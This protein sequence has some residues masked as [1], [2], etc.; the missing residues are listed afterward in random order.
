MKTYKLKNFK[1]GWICGNFLPSIIQTKL[2]EVGFKDYKEGHQEKGHVHNEAVEISVFLSGKC[3]MNE[4]ILTKGDVVVLEKG[5]SMT[6]FK[7][8]EDASTAVIKMPSVL[9]DKHELI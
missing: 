9:N 6:G 4:K 7:C 8:I 2:F 1:G 3:L 5:E